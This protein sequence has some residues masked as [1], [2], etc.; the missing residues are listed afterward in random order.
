MCETAPVLRISF[1]VGKN[2]LFFVSIL[3]GVLSVV[4]RAEGQCHNVLLSFLTEHSTLKKTPPFLGPK[5]CNQFFQ[6]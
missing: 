5:L 2:I 3:V 1:K 4:T 6:I